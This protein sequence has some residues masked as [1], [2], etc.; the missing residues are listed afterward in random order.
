MSIFS[1]NQA[2][3]GNSLNE[4]MLAEDILP[5][6]EPSYQTCKT[7]YTQHPLGAKMAESPIAMAQSQQREI[8]I[9]NSPESRVLKAFKDEWEAL[10]C[11]GHIYNTMRLARAYGIA[12]IGLLAE[13][14]PSN[15]SIDYKNL[16]QLTIA[17]NS[18]DP[19]NTAGSEVL[20]QDPNAMDFQKPRPVTVMG[21]TYHPSRTVV[22]M[23]ESP[24][25]IHYTVSAFGFVG[26]SVYQR[27]LYPMK[28][29]LRTM[30]TDDMVSRKAGVLIAKLKQAGSVINNLMAGITGQKRE[31]LNLA[32]TNNT[33]SISATDNEDVTSLNLTN[34]NTAME[35][36]RKN[37]LENIAVAA[38]MPAKLLNSETFVEGFGEGTEDA[39]AVARYIDRIRVQMSPLY[40]FFDKIVM[41][42]AWSPEFYK[43]VQAEFPE[44]YGGVPYT[45]AFYDWTNSFSATWPNLLTE[46][47]SEKVKVDD[48]KLKAAIALLEA[49]L[50]ALDPEN[51]ATVIEWIQ[52]NLNDMKFLFTSPMVLDTKALAEYVPPVTDMGQGDQE[53]QPKNEGESFAKADREPGPAM[54]AYMDALTRLQTKP[55]L[56]VV[57]GGGSATVK[58]MLETRH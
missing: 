46:P 28:S 44:E 27:A 54:R 50:P 45:K 32:E 16:P 30:I 5:G 31:M 12:S 3:V 41:Y 39:K 29:F 7:I 4:I 57:T 9:P 22:V 26:R 1:L 35:T 38:D 33:I 53:P 37:I 47:D 42:R 24:L 56:R 17:F 13:G 6:D 8:T 58:G 36:S 52:D 18:W 2:N 10:G 43:T 21:M 19:L 14:V 40:K 34:I 49:L 23:N 25:Y 48:V 20:N 11:D 15:R 55:R 51:K